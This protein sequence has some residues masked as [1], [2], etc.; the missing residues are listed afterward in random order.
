ME[1]AVIS[2]AI[3]TVRSLGCGGERRRTGTASV[4]PHQTTAANRRRPRPTRGSKRPRRLSSAA[5]ATPSP[6]S[7]TGRRCQRLHTLMK[8]PVRPASDR[9]AGRPGSPGVR[10]ATLT[11][12]PLRLSD[13]SCDSSVTITRA[14]GN[15][16]TRSPCDRK[17]H[18]TVSFGVLK[19]CEATI[20]RPAYDN[21]PR[22][23]RGHPG[24]RI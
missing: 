8:L 4:N 12:S 13:A 6:L 14:A 1:I 2:T 17:A 24:V 9:R 11:D 21:S 18:V 19:G 22:T 23:R 10:L 5:T 20:T 16:E 3:L 7:W 15:N